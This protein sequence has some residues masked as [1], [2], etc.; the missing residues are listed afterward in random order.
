ME[1]HKT[2]SRIKHSKI[3]T[4][5]LTTY[6]VI[7]IVVF[8]VSISGYILCHHILKQNLINSAIQQ[9]T[10][11]TNQIEKHIVRIQQSVDTLSQNNIID[12]FVPSDLNSEK[13][14]FFDMKNIQEMLL[15][16]CIQEPYCQDMLIYFDNDYIVSG[17]YRNFSPQLLDSFCHKYGISVDEFHQLINET[18]LY[19]W[20]IFDDGT[21]WSMRSSYSQSG[22]TDYIV[23]AQF[24]VD[25]ILYFIDETY[26]S[27]T[28]LVRSDETKLFCS[29][30]ISDQE[31]DQLAS[32][33]QNGQQLSINNQKYIWTSSAIPT[34]N[35]TCMIGIPNSDIS[36]GLKRFQQLITVELIIVILVI[37]YMSWRFA[38]KSYQPV[39]HISDILQEDLYE[40]PKN[41]ATYEE[42]YSKIHTVIEKNKSMTIKE[43]KK[44]HQITLNRF[45]QVL[46]GET[47]DQS[48]I[49]QVLD[50]CGICL[51]SS[52]YMLILIRLVDEQHIL[53]PSYY[54][55][56]TDLKLFTLKNVF[57]EVLFSRYNGTITK[58]EEDFVALLTV[59]KDNDFD[60]IRSVLNEIYAF[61]KTQL[62][63]DSYFIMCHR[64]ADFSLLSHDLKI[65]LQE[66]T[67]HIFWKD[68]DD[69]QAIWYLD[70]L[71]DEEINLSMQYLE[72]YKKFLNFLEVKDYSGAYKA[73]DYIL[74][75]TFSKDRKQL[76]RSIYRMYGLIEALI[77][78]FDM[79]SNVRDEEFLDSL[80]YENRLLNINNIHQLRSTCRDIFNSIVD[81]DTSMSQQTLP[82]R[83][84]LI[85]DFIQT[86]YMDAN[87][88]V[89]M[90][91]EHFNIS[92][93]HLSRSFKSNLN[94][95]ILDYIHQ[96]RLQKAKELILSEKN[97]NSVA[98]STGF[99]D[100][101]ALTRTFKKYEGITPSQ[102]RQTK[103]D[104]TYQK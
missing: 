57:D 87:L 7:G 24:K 18:K 47:T 100:S 17:T 10:I 5:I 68:S 79:R 66:M 38:K 22:K 54:S 12:Q 60:S 35:W 41:Q 40:V 28:V 45:S 48:A 61:F 19:N 91:A 95:G 34:L 4:S 59:D 11:I 2:R 44:A 93:P 85:I 63:I 71:S 31:Y 55:E 86:H 88:N 49:E 58:Y 98:I 26:R 81:Y 83:M 82:E 84:K 90:I 6:I 20:K 104:P 27:N 29:Q 8:I 97:L 46:S 14:D 77:T 64:P 37:V 16:T 39:K 13:I 50:N 52:Y 51:H 96:V 43:Q 15:G 73:L 53:T 33:S 56:D 103:T 62:H 99:L 76:N 9:S 36:H 70:E 72:V 23:I 102:Y 25:D 89:S 78:S 74:T 75:Y 67:W 65:L 30:D 32:I 69:N 1:N 42:L 80:D 3:F 101:K 94:C 21:I 92:V